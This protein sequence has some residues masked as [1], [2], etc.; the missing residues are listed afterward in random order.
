L[1]IGGS[2]ARV[3]PESAL[4]RL[5]RSQS[6]I[7]SVVPTGDETVRAERAEPPAGRV[8]RAESDQIRRLARPAMLRKDCGNPGVALHFDQDRVVVEGRQ[9]SHRITDGEWLAA[10]ACCG[11]LRAETEHYAALV[12]ADRIQWTKRG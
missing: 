2:A 11:V 10:R 7:R 4:A 1:V 3:L 6:A 5:A 8:R 9:N 12:V